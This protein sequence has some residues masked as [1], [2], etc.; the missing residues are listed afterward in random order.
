M[1]GTDASDID[2]LPVNGNDDT[3]VHHHH[4][5]VTDN[6][7]EPWQSAGDITT[8]TAAA[9]SVDF[10]LTADSSLST[11]DTSSNGASTLST[12][13]TNGTSTLVTSDTNGVSTTSAGD[14]VGG[15]GSFSGFIVAMHRKM[16]LSHILLFITRCY[17]VPFC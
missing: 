15:D 1:T 3:P 7:D 16:V 2:S 10:T 8:A 13:D 17:S 5:H 11:A 6:G 9:D 4:H 12:S 14:S